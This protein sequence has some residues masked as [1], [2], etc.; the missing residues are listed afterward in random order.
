[1]KLT[2]EE[3]RL[4]LALL[5]ASTPACAG[6]RVK[7]MCYLNDAPL[8]RAYYAAQKQVLAGEADSLGAVLTDWSPTH[9][10]H[11]AD[12]DCSL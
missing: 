3:T 11:F 7:L 1:M 9:L 8:W 4:V 5:T 6:L 12:M 2:T 10:S